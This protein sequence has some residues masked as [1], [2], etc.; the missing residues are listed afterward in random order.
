MKRKTVQITNW[1]WQ[2]KSAQNGIKVFF[3][4]FEWHSLARNFFCLFLLLSDFIRFCYSTATIVHRLD[5][6]RSKIVKAAA[7]KQTHS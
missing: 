5:A 7:F 3:A 2:I 1:I 4:R 6:F